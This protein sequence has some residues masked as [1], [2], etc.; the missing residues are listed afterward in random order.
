MYIIKILVKM[1]AITTFLFIYYI[2]YTTTSL[3]EKYNLFNIFYNFKVK[4]EQK[5]GI[6]E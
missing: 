5:S 2:L 6:F 3:F 1:N 4:L